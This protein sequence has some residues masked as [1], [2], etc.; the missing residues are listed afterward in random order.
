MGTAL[1]EFIKEEVPDWD[2][3]IVSAVRFKAFSGQRSDWEPKYWFWRDLIIKIARHLG[4]TVIHASEL[5]KN[6]FVRNGLTPLCMDRV[7]LEMY[8]DGDILR[9]RDLK[10]PSGGTLYGLFKRALNLV[11]AKRSDEILEEPLILP[12][13]VKE[14]ATE[15]ISSLSETNWTSC[16][17]ITMGKFRGLC[18]GAD[19][20]TAIFSYLC[21]SAQARYLLITKGERIEGMKLSLLAQP[22]PAATRLDYDTLHLVWT[23]ERLQQQLD[24]VNSRYRKSKDAA[25]ASLKCGNRQDAQR[26]VRHLKLATDSRSKCISLL[27]RVEEVLGVIA[28]AEATKKAT[29]A[30][31]I[32]ARSIKENG[33]SVEEVHL[34]LQELTESIDSQKQAEEIL[35]SAPFPMHDVDMDDEEIEE[36]FKKLETELGESVEPTQMDEGVSA[37]VRHVKNEELVESLGNALSR[38]TLEPA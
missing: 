14:R 8:N 19:E 2:D 13:L 9:F 17:V 28:D 35:A 10:D 36:E 15:I 27:N 5:R 37:R 32:G 31:Q 18:K 20:A 16:C 26:H 33:I 21:E 11:A 12:T 7:L 1:K 3:D 38:V 6:W 29:E 34:C 4:I 23:V 22:V 30:I 24:V 25:V